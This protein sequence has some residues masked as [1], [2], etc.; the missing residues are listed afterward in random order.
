[1]QCGHTR[2]WASQCPPWVGCVT[3][4]PEHLRLG[5]EPPG[6]YQIKIQWYLKSL[7]WGLIWVTVCYC[8]VVKS[9]L[10]LFV[11]PWTDPSLTQ[12]MWVWVNSRSWWWTGRLGVLQSMGS[13]RLRH[14]WVTELTTDW[15]FNMHLHFLHVFWWFDSSFLSISG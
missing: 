6:T 12:W 3:V 8:L 10:I 9:R 15:L 2:V 7:I 5:C 11:T 4:T 13:Q 1:M 14:D